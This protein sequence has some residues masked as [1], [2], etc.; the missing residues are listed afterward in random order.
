M[1]FDYENEKSWYLI[2]TMP[3]K[4]QA[5]AKNI[6]QRIIS[7]NMQDF[8]FRTLIPEHKVTF[9]KGNT[10]VEKNEKVYPGTVFVE[11][12]VTDESWF[13][14]RN[15]PL[16]AGIL[17]SSGGGAKPVPVAEEEMTAILKACG[18]KLEVELQYK[19]GDTVLIVNGGF[20]GETGVVESID[21]E[22]QEVVVLIDLMGRQSPLPLGLGDVK[23][24]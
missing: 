6:E 20:E 21:T 15:T 4:E 17:G 7:Q 3:G 23:P 2:Q 11:M 18:I 16:V 13:M 22:K 1:G 8:V 19:V 14:V 10:K 24:C 9:M 5:C 12:I